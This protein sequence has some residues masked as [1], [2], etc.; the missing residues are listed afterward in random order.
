M[1]DPAF[2]ALLAFAKETAALGRAAGILS[3]DQEVMMPPKA[4]A[5]RAES[6]AALAGVL[7]ERRTDPRLGAWLA[8]A[9]RAALDPVALRDLELTER[10]HLRALRV[11]AALASRLAGLASRAQRIWAEARAAEDFAAFA[12]TL[13]EMVAARREEAEA[14]AEPG[15]DPYDALLEEYEPGMTAAALDAIFARL[16]EGLAPLA[17]EAAARGP[18][19]ALAGHFP[20]DA[21]LA[22]AREVATAFRYDWDAGR[23]DLAVHPFSSGQ[24]GDARITTRIDEADPFNCLYSTIHEVGHAVY[25][26]NIAGTLFGRPAGGFASMGV[27]E[28]QSRFFENQ[29]GRSRAFAEWLAPR[30]A[31]HLAEAPSD[32]QRFFRAANRIQPGFIRTEADEVHYNLH[33]LMRFDLERDLLSGRLAAK[34]LAEAWRARFE[35]DFGTPPPNDR[36]GALQDVHWSLGLIGYFPTYSLGNLNAAGL[37]DAMRRDLPDLDDRMAVGDLAPIVAWLTDRVHRHGA[38][39][40]APALIEAATGAPLSE[41]PLLAHL[42]RKVDALA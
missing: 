9:D 15:Q 31:A 16:R 25:E 33:I 24:Q 20:K 39:L 18:S 21:Q 35:A 32:A 22:L 13:A 19:P 26:Q 34:D 11:P 27:H 8:A 36:L 6:A 41:K 30:A 17:A 40:P 14:L 2:D 7:H 37:E 5:G 10:A 38:T 4:A 12:P 1:S 28:S 23:L 42:R 29:I 3:W